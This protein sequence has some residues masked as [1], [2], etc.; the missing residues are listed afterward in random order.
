MFYLEVLF[1]CFNSSILGKA[2]PVA[3]PAPAAAV[4]APAGKGVKSAPQA[5]VPAPLP[6]IS[7]PAKGGSL[8]ISIL[9]FLVTE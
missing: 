9:S 6:S 8:A 2:A 7:Q 5:A 1:F 3:A 4:S